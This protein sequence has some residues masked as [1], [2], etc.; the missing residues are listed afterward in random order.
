MTLRDGRAPGTV[1]VRA[2]LSGA[3]P[4]R[5]GLPGHVSIVRWRTTV[6]R[7]VPQTR[8]A[9]SRRSQLAPSRAPGA[10]DTDGAAG[11]GASRH[12]ARGAPGHPGGLPGEC[13]V[14]IRAG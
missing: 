11:P 7:P 14:G 4:E 2:P 8:I 12:R 1:T 3:P 10:S 13:V 5:C 6:A 9:H